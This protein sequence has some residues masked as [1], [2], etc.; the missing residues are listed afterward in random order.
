VVTG[1][2]FKAGGTVTISLDDRALTTADVDA[3]GL[4]STFFA[5]PGSRSGDYA[6]TISDG[7][8]SEELTFTVQTVP[9]PVPHPSLPE[10]G[11]EVKAPI[12]FDWENVTAERSPVTYSLQVATESNFSTASIVVEKEGLAQS[13]YTISEE[14]A[15][16]LI[17]GETPYYWRIRAV[18]ADD[19]EGE[20][21]GPGEFFFAKPFSM[22]SWAIY[23]LLG[24]GALVLFAIGYWMGRRTAYYYS[25]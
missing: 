8:S 22:P 7:T 17:G 10:M 25:L 19:N 18:D 5:V 20:W 1:A 14:E 4:F 21:T 24:V 15:V 16:K 12:L 13:E 3:N 11:V 23:T 2:G 9:P 6:L